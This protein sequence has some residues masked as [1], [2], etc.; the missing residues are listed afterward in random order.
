VGLSTDYAGMQ[1]TRPAARPRLRA[2]G[3]P[4]YGGR[5]SRRYSSR[6]RPNPAARALRAGIALTG[7]LVFL[8][9]AGGAVLDTAHAGR[10]LP[11]VHFEGVA[12]GGL[13][14]EQARS[15]LEPHLNTFLASPATFVLGDRE[16]RP[17][18]AEMGISVDTAAMAQEAARLG[19][20]GVWPLRY[21][22]A[23]ATT[24]AKPAV[25]LRAAL[26]P[27]QLSAFL[28]AVAAEIDREPVNAGLQVRNGQLVTGQSAPGRKV[29]I[30]A[31]LDR[32]AVPSGLAPQ[33]VEV[34]VT[35]TQPVLSDAAV[36]EAQAQAARI[37]ASPLTLRLGDKAWT[38]T[39]TQ[40]GAMLEFRRAPSEGGERLVAA[41]SEPRLAAHVK[42]LAT[43][44]DRPATEAQLRWNGS[45]ATVVRPSAD[46][47]RLDQPAAVRAILAQAT[48]DTREVALPAAVTKPAVSSD[49]ALV[50][51]IKEPLAFGSS[52]FAGSS[53]ERVNNIQI[54]ARR[55][56][57]AVIA[58]GGTFSF[59]K[60]LGPITNENGYQEGL[61]IQGDATVP[62]IG[63]GVCQV[64]T[65]VFRAAFFAGLPI[66]ERH[67]HSYRV[68]YYEQD[69]SPVG[70]DAAVYDPGVDL[71]F[72]NDTEYAILMHANVDTA[73][74]TLTFRFYST[75][76]GRDVK[77]TPQKANEIKAGPKLP[78]VLDPKLPKGTRKQVEWSADGVDATIRRTVTS[79]ADGPALFSDAFFSRYVPW[80]EKWAVGPS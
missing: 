38:L 31:T 67:Q 79:G 22:G 6:R 50:A 13:A 41:L 24:A 20:A 12:L 74:S 4:V 34:A 59:L 27:T 73:T 72:R 23:V 43:E 3:G 26:N 29:D 55:L 10:A 15:V 54:A 51:T 76:T 11:T 30:K 75:K 25:P 71:R 28:H 17:T 77:L 19:R 57:G 47:I 65:T 36:Q 40:L 18:A 56:D 33:R 60:A 9:G 78:D 53:P 64:S 5:P 70:F 45:G 58:P 62:G 42:T 52:K 39:P 48:S 14:P 16:W 80:R 49:P 37:L 68:G 35:T 1:L 61:T 63:G 66:V 32:V 21:F 69:G 46:G 2:A 7:L 8:T 44:V